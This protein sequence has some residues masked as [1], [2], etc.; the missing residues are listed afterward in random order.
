MPTRYAWILVTC[1][2]P[3]PGFL[4]AKVNKADPLAAQQL[5]QYSSQT[6]RLCL[7]SL[8]CILVSAFF[9]EVFQVQKITSVSLLCLGLAWSQDFRA[10]ITGQITDPSKAPLPNASVKAVKDGTNDCPTLI[11]VVIQSRSRHRASLRSG[12]PSYSG[13]PT[14]R[15]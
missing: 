2:G 11:R 5:S 12:E 8:A 4:R 10:T 7:A 9:L 14:A 13:S 15:T 1:T 6:F 3:E